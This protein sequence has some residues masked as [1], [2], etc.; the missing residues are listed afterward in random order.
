MIHPETKVKYINDAIGY[1][2]FATSDIAKGTIIYV[3]DMFDIVI[4]KFKYHTL[5]D[6]H[7]KLVD[8]YSYRD[9]KGQRIISWDIGKY[10]N[11]KC[12]CNTMSTG[13]GFEIAIKDIKAGEEVTDDYGL[14]NLSHS[15]KVMCNCENCRKI[16]GPTDI[17]HYATEWD[18]SVIDALGYLNSVSQPL[19]EYVETETRKELKLYFSERSEY[20]SVRELKYC[21]TSAEHISRSNLPIG[22][23]NS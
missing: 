22:L 6:K 3:E 17:E 14:F 4:S 15:M 10:V 21:K 23:N 11:H 19:Y 2:V 7:K 20:K 18:R 9:A 5:D 13:Y 16:V 1:G 8:K 12:E